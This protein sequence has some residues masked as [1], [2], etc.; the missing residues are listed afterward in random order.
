M[1]ALGNACTPRLLFSGRF[2]CSLHMLQVAAVWTWLAQR[3][4]SELF[5][6]ID[7]V[8]DTTQQMV[9][10]MEQGLQVRRQPALLQQTICYC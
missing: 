9:Q 4:G 1:S 3:F 8:R 6:G 2:D 10:L 7:E 5:P